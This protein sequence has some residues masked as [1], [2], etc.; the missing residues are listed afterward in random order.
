[1]NNLEK[2]I[3]VAIDGLTDEEWDKLI[4]A[5]Q[6]YSEYYAK[7]CLKIAADRAEI[8]QFAGRSVILTNSITDINLPEHD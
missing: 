2:F 6:N 4:L 3:T 1:M 5:V 8:I 7:K